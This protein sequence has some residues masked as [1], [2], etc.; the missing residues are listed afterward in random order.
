MRKKA[1]CLNSLEVLGVSLNARPAHPRSSLFIANLLC[2]GSTNS[3]WGDGGGVQSGQG[4]EVSGRFQVAKV[5]RERQAE[6]TSWEQD[7]ELWKHGACCVKAGGVHELMVDEGSGGWKE[8]KR[9]ARP[10]EEGSSGTWGS[11]PRSLCGLTT[12][13]T[14]RTNYTRGSPESRGLEA[15]LTQA[16]VS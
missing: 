4:A 6:G 14:Q 3:V 8:A 15:W 7:T 5:D 1:C 13:G 9:W 10:G 16:L 2:P 12:Q 11:T